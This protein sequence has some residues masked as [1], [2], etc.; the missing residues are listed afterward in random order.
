MFV[1][2]HGLVDRKAPELEFGGA[3]NRVGGDDVAGEIANH[4]AEGIA[5]DADV[6]RRGAEADRG[7]ILHGLHG[8]GLAARRG[9]DRPGS[10]LGESAR[11]DAHA[12]NVVSEGGDAQTRRAGLNFNAVPQGMGTG[13]GFERSDVLRG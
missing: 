4:Q 13:Y 3:A 2:G 8:D 7:G 6:E 1:A 10:V 11:G 9:K 5:L 12:E